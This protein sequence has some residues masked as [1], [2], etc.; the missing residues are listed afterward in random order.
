VPQEFAWGGTRALAI[1]QRH[2]AV[3]HDVCIR[4]GRL[5]GS[6]PDMTTTYCGHDFFERPLLYHFTFS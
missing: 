2:A 5:K 4:H 1:F 6:Q 3:D